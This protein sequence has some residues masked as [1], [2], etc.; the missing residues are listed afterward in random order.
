LREVERRNGIPTAPFV[1]RVAEGAEVIEDDVLTKLKQEP[2]S[3][4]AGRVRDGDLLLCSGNDPFSRLIGWATASPWT[5]VALAYRWPALGRIMVFESVQTLGVRTVPLATFIRQSSTGK[6]PYPGKIILARHDD[7][8]DRAGKTGSAAMK[9][10]ADFAVD[11]FGDP[12]AGTEIIKIAARICLGSLNRKMPKFMGPKNEFICSE[13]AA[14]CFEAVGIEI[15]W[16]GLGFIAPADFA[17][18]PK[19]R[20]IAQFQTR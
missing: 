19:S 8:A 15:L 17:R 18:D 3:A 20:A 16:D 5:H 12:F 13:Y 6:R 1:P 11:R 2:L 7:Y 14:R 4:I 10:L 9:R